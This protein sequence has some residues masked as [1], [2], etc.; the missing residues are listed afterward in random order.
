MCSSDLIQDMFKPTKLFWKVGKHVLRY[1]KGT[2]EYGIWYRP[3][4]GVN[5]QGFTDADWAGSPLDRKRTL[6]G[7]FS[8]R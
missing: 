7:I 3:I 1:I 4:E 5:I 2:I 8:I 6:G